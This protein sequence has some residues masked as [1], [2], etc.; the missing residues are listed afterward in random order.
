MRSQLVTMRPGSPIHLPHPSPLSGRRG[1]QRSDPF[2]SPPPASVGEPTRSAST[3]GMLGRLRRC[4]RSG[5]RRNVPAFLNFRAV[6]DSRGRQPA[7]VVAEPRDQRLVEVAG[8]DALQVEDRDQHFEALRLARVGRQI[9]DEKRMRSDPSLT[10]S[11]TPDSARQP[12]RCRIIGR[13]LAANS[14]ACALGANACAAAAA[15]LRK[16]SA[17][18]LDWVTDGLALPR[19]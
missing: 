2:G 17:G 11:R 5:S 7:S 4:S 8:R 10:R 19:T 14:A 18:D 3:G 9:A 1:L 6:S 13:M 15:T 12:D 16:R